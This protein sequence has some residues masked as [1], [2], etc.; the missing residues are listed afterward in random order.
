MLKRTYVFTED[1]IELLDSI[2]YSDLERVLLELP[3]EDD[4]DAQTQI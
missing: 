3:P 2:P 1:Y 4:S